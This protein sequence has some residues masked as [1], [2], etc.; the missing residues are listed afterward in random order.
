MYIY[1]IS[2][3]GQHGFIVL[4]DSEK[5][6]DSFDQKNIKNKF[7]TREANQPTKEE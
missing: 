6:K 1:N 7:E 5:E 3:F 4:I 2:M